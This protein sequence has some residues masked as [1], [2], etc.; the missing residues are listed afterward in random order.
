M[1]E[2]ST[3]NWLSSDSDLQMPNDFAIV[4]EN[5]VVLKRERLVEASGIDTLLCKQ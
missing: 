4:I 1:C 3:K 5:L 2:K